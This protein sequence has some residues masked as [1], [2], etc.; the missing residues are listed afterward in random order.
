MCHHSAILHYSLLQILEDLGTLTDNSWL[1][2]LVVT[3]LYTHISNTTRLHA[4]KEA[5][6]EFRPNPVVKPSN[7][8]LV[9]FMEFVLTKTNFQFNSDHYLRVSGTSMG[10]K[11][12]PS[13]VNV[14]MGKL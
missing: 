1:V 10:T 9:Q 14:F 3:Q 11:M 4:A 7:D 8:S 6:G 12:A 2:T 13:Y 5:L